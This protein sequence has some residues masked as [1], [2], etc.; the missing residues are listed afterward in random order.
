[1]SITIAGYNLLEVVYEDTNTLIYRALRE[2]DQIPVIIKTFKAEYPSLEELTRLRHEYKILQALDLEGTIKPIALESYQNRLGLVLPDFDGETLEKIIITRKLGL[3]QFLQIA[4]HLAKTLVVLHQNNIIH[5]D[6]KPHNILINPQTGEVKLIDFSISSRLS[7]EHQTVSNPNLLEGTLAYMSPEQTGRMNRSVDYRTDFYSLGITFYEM[8]TGQLPFKANEP[9]EIIHCH[10]AK[11]PVP[12]HLIDSEIPEAV[13]DIVMKLLAKTAEDR[14]QSALGLKADLEICLKM[15][16]TSGKISHFQVGELDLF[17]QFSIPQKLYGR[18]QEVS[19]LIDAF[20]RVASGQE[21]RVGNSP[22]SPLGKGGKGGVE[23]MLVSGY[24]GIGK[25]S[26]V[27][28]IHKPI[29]A[30][31]GYFISGKFDQFQ[32]N[33]P[34]SAIINAFQSLVKQLLTESEAQLAQW[35]EKL[36]AALGTNAQ[37]IIDVVPEVELIIGKQPVAPE[38][39]PTEAQN[40]FNLVFQNFIRV[41]C[42]QEHPL[43]IFSDD[44]QWADSATLKLLEVIMADAETGYLLF[45]GAYRDNEVNPMHPLMITLDSLRSK[46]VIINNI[47][48]APLALDHI[49]YL[50]A[51]TL[52]SNT[53]AVKPLA[54]LVI[55]KTSGNPFFVNQFLKTLYQ[56]NLLTFT[57]PSQDIQA[58]WKWDIA[59]I[60]A[61]GI[62]DNVVDL[63]IRKL[64]K[65]PDATQQVL[66][67]AACVGNTFDLKTLSIIYNQSVAV[68]YRDLWGAIK[69]GLILPIS[70]L[71]ILPEEIIEAH[72]VSLHFKFLH[73]RVQQAA[74]ALIDESFKKVTHLQI[75]RLLWQNSSPETLSAQIFEIVDHLN[76]GIGLISDESERNAIAQLNLIAGQ[77][78]K[79]ATAY[80]AATEYLLMGLGLLVD[81]SWESQYDLTLSL[82]NEAAEAAFLNGDSDAL[83]RLVEIV[84][85]R[86]KTLLDKVK[87]YEV[88]IQAYMGQN[89]LKEA[90]NTGLQVLKLLGI[91]F[92]EQLNPSEIG[93]GLEETA[94][95][96]NGKKP[97]DL[98]GLPQMTDSDKLAALRL[99]SSTLS[100]AIFCAPELVPLV[101]C[102]QINLSVQYGNASMSPFAYSLYGGFLC[103][104]VGDIEQGYQ[105]GQL[106]LSLLSKWNVK[107]ISTKTHHAVNVL[108]QHW[109]ELVRNGLESFRSNYYNGLENGDLEYGSYSAFEYGSHSYLAGQQLTVLERE[110]ALYWDAI[111]KIK[112]E[113]TLHY[114]EIYWQAILNLMGKT[115]S[116]WIL[117]GEVYDEQIMLPQHQRT[118]D[119]MAVYFVHF[120]KVLLCY[121]FEEYSA[122]IINSDIAEKYL[123]A[124]AGMLAFPIFHFYDSL[125]RLAVY[126]SSPQSEQKVILDKIQANQEK[127]QKWAHHAPMNFLHKFYLVEAERHRVL[128]EKLEAMEMYDEA[129]ALAKENE[130]INEEALANE[131]AAKFYLSWGKEA[132]AQLY[133]QKAHYAYQ[134]W[135]AQRKVEDLE[136][137]YPQLLAG[138]SVKSRPNTTA[139]K[140]TTTPST[141]SHFRTSTSLDL[142]TVMKAAQAISGEIVLSNLLS[143]LMK[144]AIENAGAEKGFLILDKSG[145]LLIEAQGNIEQDDVMVLQSIPLDDSHELPISIINYVERT[146]E[147][148]VLKDASASEIFATD[149][150]ILNNQPKSVLCTPLIHQCKLTGILYLENNLTTDAFT[151]DRLE[152]LKLLST[153]AA[154]SIENARLYTDL[155]EALQNLETKV[156]QRTLELQENNI[157]LQQE[158]RVSEAAVRHRQRAEKAA[159]A[160]NHAKSEFLANMSHELRTPLNGILGY[161]QILKKDKTLTG[162]QKN[163]IGII[164]QCGEHLLTLINDILDLSKIEA[165]RMELYPKEFYFPEFIETLTEICR[166]RAEQK[167]ISLIYKSL[168]P[169]PKIIQA[170]EK[171]LRQILLNL[172]SNAVKFTEK[173][174]IT[175]KIGYVMEPR[176]GKPGISNANTQS[177]SQT[178]PTPQLRFQVEDTG[179]GIAPE[180]LEEIFLPFQQVGE[181]SRKTEG[182]GLGLTISRQ[183][184]EMMGAS[185]KVKSTLGKGSIF[186]LDLDLPEVSLGANMTNLHERNIIGFNGSK[187]KV[188]VVDDQWANRSVLVNLLEPLGFE[189]L[190]ATNGQDGLSK[191]REFKPDVIFMDLVMPVLDGFEATRRI[192]MLPD[193]H[194]VVVISISASVFALDQQQ[195][196]EVGCNDFIAK[197]IRE[198]ELLEKLQVH[199]GLEWVYEQKDEVER[200]K[201]E[202][203]RTKDGNISLH[204]SDFALEGAIVAPPA[205]ELAVLLDLAM[206][207]DL[208]GIVEQATRLEALD[209]QWVPF[210]THLR[211][212]AKSFKGKEIL[213]FLKKY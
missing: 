107:E 182:T 146:H 150:Y 137:K 169:L 159:D 16:Q 209:Q 34:Y 127:M 129:I 18:E 124:A 162:Q 180:Q 184:V 144:I 32:R 152:V 125:V 65:L 28:E 97:S 131:L 194:T 104:L 66:Q 113:T 59:Q 75:G 37:V 135:G 177:K 111:Q 6:I 99:L 25:S 109:K 46:A 186:W 200:I 52:H 183:L 33:V 121:W 138:T 84:Q 122:A 55:R 2:L 154:I 63:M 210:A 187:R 185:L 44:L 136:E 67:L 165:R 11:T 93:R 153:Q 78:A 19:L 123:N 29:V 61:I 49:S 54:E 106:A 189:V 82:H 173:G 8:L 108:V 114:H 4:I 41:F 12:P 43:V 160:A 81:S 76:L 20:V 68:A 100:S 207:G 86:A 158:I 161:T 79:A 120:N 206:R 132:I 27:N 91:E 212:L 15:L 83:Q 168:S 5:K 148:V 17:S 181:D 30:A 105:F 167:G 166:I 116:P 45:I 10:I 176:D 198:A 56:E 98:I 58:F 203:E 40:R 115:Q 157:R 57:P 163:G 197:P 92:P 13:S 87:V 156:E 139:N 23:M 101:V 1:M 96:L 53:I 178:S 175:F 172:L 31:R 24:S 201:D 102:K 3:I 196:Q 47:T 204:T 134:V 140:T 36:L 77:K 126:L 22:F 133:M 192:R 74:Y 42:S 145:S 64:R 130:Y 35:K 7:R 9:L 71:K 142:A 205:E 95:I 147:N 213:Y 143:Q 110:M 90:V 94:S 171:R 179:I 38:L 62:T 72:L 170:D 188:L 119:R 39:A 88:Q 51:D 89:K 191:A 195:S 193:L 199:L 80:A 155:E 69:E 21:K 149:A 174:S 50:I 151:S 117:R 208:R 103:G 118:N 26:L 14:Y 190:E 202:V 112:Q 48:L 128:G 211:Q 141:S 70:E 85:N 60:E 164:H 73:D